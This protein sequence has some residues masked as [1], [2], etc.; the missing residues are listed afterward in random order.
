LQVI[1]R[2]NLVSNARE[3]GAIMMDELRGLAQR[4]E[5]IGDVRGAGLF[6]GVEVVKDRIRKTPD[7][8]ITMKLVNG[9]RRKRVL[10]GAAGPNANV[11]QDPAANRL[12]EG[13]C[14]HV[15]WRARRSSLRFLIGEP[16]ILKATRQ[17]PRK[18]VHKCRETYGKLLVKEGDH[19]SPGTEVFIMESMKTEV[20]HAARV[21]G[22]VKAVYITEGQEGVDAEFVAVLIE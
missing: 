17:W 7:P 16:H 13:E 9:L 5:A 20:P 22:T 11:S 3:V 12:H 2:D 21:G 8:K 18:S 19:V 14:R 10:I 15:H 6:L 1:E 4:H